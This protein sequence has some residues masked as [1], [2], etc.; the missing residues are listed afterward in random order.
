MSNLPDGWIQATFAD[1]IADV[2]NGIGGT[3]N[4]DSVGIPVSR[5]ETIADET[6]NFAKVGYLKDYDQTKLDKYLL[7]SGDILFSHI[8]SPTHL[9]KTV[10]YRTKQRLYHGINLLRIMTNHLVAC[11][12]YFNFYCKLTRAKGEFALKAQHAVNQSSLNQ[13]K[14]RQFEIPLAPLNEQKRIADKLVAVLARVDACSDRLD[15]IPI[16]IKRFRQSVL[17]AA[18]S[19][20]LTEDWRVETNAADWQQTDVQSVAQVGTGST[21]LR[22]NPVFFSSLGT[23]WASAA[24]SKALV[25]SADEFVTQAAI[26]AHR[27]KT[28]PIGTLLVAMYG[29][30]KTRGQVTELGISATINQACAAIVVNEEK[31]LRNYVKLALQ[32]N[33]FEMRELAEGGNQPNLNRKRSLNCI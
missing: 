21:P 16:I 33:Y 29:E 31:A 24:T 30:G 4:K 25:T 14:L 19:G 20:A 22:S 26:T 23:P 18:T 1:V 10:I 2:T 28:Y 8:N 9:G 13:T 3:Q 11:P 12:E 7:K 15:R 6:I 27:L 32:A 5:I 17:S